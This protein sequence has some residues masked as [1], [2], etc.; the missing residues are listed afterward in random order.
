MLKRLAGMSSDMDSKHLD[1]ASKMSD[2]LVDCLVKGMHCTCKEELE[3]KN[4]MQDRSMDDVFAQV[5]ESQTEI[6]GLRYDLFVD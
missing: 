2:R 1:T 4:V 3:L 5:C 6:S